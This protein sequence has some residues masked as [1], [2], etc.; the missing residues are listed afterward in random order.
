MD[1]ILYF[2]KLEDKYWGIFLVAVVFLFAVGERQKK[3]EEWYMAACYGMLSYLVFICPLTYKLMSKV[4]PDSNNYYELSH[5]W[6]VIAIVPL[7]FSAAW[8]LLSQKGDRRR[9]KLYLAMGGF[10]VLFFAGQLV[11][12]DLEAKPDQY[13]V[14]DSAQTQVYDMILADAESIGCQDDITLW[15][16]SALMAKSRIYDASFLPVYGKDIAQ[17]EDNYSDTAKILYHG[18]SAYEAPDSLVINKDQQLWAIALFMNMYDEAACRY[19]VIFDPKSQGSDVDAGV[20]FAECNFDMVGQADDLQVY[21][22]NG[23]DI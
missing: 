20:I 8:E 12:T 6:L 18:Y 4:L 16:P 21:R 1:I 10:L 15:G 19:V 3:Q 5:I 14:Y 23:K 9:E 7:A 11:Y 2:M 22:Y 13:G 17:S